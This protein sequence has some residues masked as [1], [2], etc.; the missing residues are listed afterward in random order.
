V[1]DDGTLSNR[2]AFA[3]VSPGVPDGIHVDLK[4]NV[5]TGCAD[6][7]QVFNP[8][9]KLIGKIYLGTTSANFQWAGKGRMV[10]LAETELYFATLASEGA[11]PGKMY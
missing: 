6:G 1:Q 7:V 2:K 11:F 5:Y 9:G 8:S 4:G 10:I 3:F